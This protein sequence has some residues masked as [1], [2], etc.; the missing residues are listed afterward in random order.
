MKR[1]VEISL[2][3]RQCTWKKCLFQWVAAK[4]KNNARDHFHNGKSRDSDGI[5][6]VA[7]PALERDYFSLLF[8]CDEGEQC[9]RNR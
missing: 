3:Q 7:A 4:L 9:E 5:R 6:G 1:E 8:L 2:A